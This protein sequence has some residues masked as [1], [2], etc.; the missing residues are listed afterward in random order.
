MNKVLDSTKYV[1]ENSRDVSVDSVALESVCGGIEKSELK[2]WTEA[3]PIDFSGFNLREKLMFTLVF[4][5]M[6]FCYWG[7]PKWTVEYKGEEHDGSWGMMAALASEIE[8]AKVRE[9]KSILDPGYLSNINGAEMGRILW[10]NVM[11]PLFQE[12]SSILNEIGIVLS[13][14]YGGDVGR[15]VERSGLD[16]LKLLEVI[17]DD[18]PSFDDVSTYDDKEVWFYKRAQL[19]V[20]DIDNVLRQEGYPGLRN[21]GELT[22]CADYKIP[23]VLRREKVLKYSPELTEKVDGFVLLGEG[24]S[25]EVEI[26]ANTIWAVE[27]MKETLG[28][29]IPGITAK[30]I[31]DYLWLE[32]QTKFPDDKPYHRTLTTNY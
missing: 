13:S 7:K 27:L 9:E 10:G 29:K 3:A 21:V 23:Q 30:Q 32:G 5:S 25:E 4:N 14:D 2:H 18:F 28:K 19:L 6:S 12:R 22:A 15:L 31:N 11:I 8:L 26:R 20:A 16:G 17:V 1:F 24:C